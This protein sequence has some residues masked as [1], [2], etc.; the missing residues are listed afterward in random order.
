MSLT[1]TF[2]WSD[3]TPLAFDWSTSLSWLLVR[4]SSR[5]F[6]SCF[7]I[8][9]A[10]ARSTYW[11]IEM[12]HLWSY[13]SSVNMVFNESFS[14]PTTWGFRRNG[15][16]DYPLNTYWLTFVD[17]H[18]LKLFWGLCLDVW[19]IPKTCS[20]SSALTLLMKSQNVLRRDW[21][22]SYCSFAS[23]LKLFSSVTII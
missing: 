2:Y 13:Y 8:T 22:F 12:L 1:L 20:N 14:D 11:P 15:V 5:R 23:R 6:R 7:R 21:S 19:S 16:R 9:G 3:L 10:I 18:K 4:T 17:S